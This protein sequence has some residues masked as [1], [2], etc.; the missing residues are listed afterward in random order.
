MKK[1]RLL[2]KVSICSDIFSEMIIADPTSNKIYVQWMLNLFA[3]LIKDLKT[4]S[5]GIRLV[6]EDLPQANTY[7]TLFE[8][9]KRKKEIQRFMFE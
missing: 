1:D 8:E 6:G 9:H 7:L 3:R 2:K 4:Q 5:F